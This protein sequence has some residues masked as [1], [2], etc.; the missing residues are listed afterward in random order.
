ML[1]RREELSLR[2]GQQ[3]EFMDLHERVRRFNL[4]APRSYVLERE[5][6]PA[7]QPSAS[8]DAAFR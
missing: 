3:T 1:A 7:H 8:D 2:P 4:Q 5:E 6:E